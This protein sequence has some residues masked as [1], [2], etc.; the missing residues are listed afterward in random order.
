MG[1]AE[2]GEERAKVGS[3]WM[4]TIPVSDLDTSIEFYHQT[5]GLP[6]LLDSRQNNW[7]ELGKEQGEGGIALYVPST[8]DDV[9]PGDSTGIVFQ[10]RDIYEVHQRLVDLGVEFI[11]KP[12]RQAWG[13][14]IATFL[15]P[16]GNVLMLMEDPEHYNRAISMGED[17][18]IGG[19][20]SR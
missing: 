14:M 3:I 7:V 12:E 17:A 2:G 6:I 10:T 13:G 9:K 20:W 19:S 15:D 4:V 5:L 18:D 16:D 11:L 8:F 1:K